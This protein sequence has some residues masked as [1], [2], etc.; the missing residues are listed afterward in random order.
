MPSER[1][2]AERRV[3]V[4]YLLL[5]VVLWGGNYTWVKIA[6]RDVGP[7]WFNAFRYGGAVLLFLAVMAARG[8]LRGL[9]PEP[10]E[11][12]AL[13][14]VGLLQAGLMTT[15]TA[16]ALRWTDASQVV[17]IAYTVPIWALLWGAAVLREAVTAGAALG[18]GLGLTGIAILTDPFGQTWQGGTMTG[19]AAALVGVNGWAL[20]AVLYR[21]RAWASSFWRQVWWQL[22]ATAL[23]MLVLAPLMEDWHEVRFSPS[24]LAVVAWNATGPTLLGFFFWAQAL[25]RV[26]AATAG[27]VMILAPVFGVLQSHLVLA[28]PLQ[29]GLILAALLVTAGA[30]LALR[31]A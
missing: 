27:Q 23:A 29:P 1:A 6:V 15:M 4:G 30:W 10:G 2:G 8:K 7:L 9:L 25:S 17:L 18:A 21:R 12:S 20:G 22:L 26:T 24:M 19:I 14:V 16:L 11:R 31:Q 13:A 5:L 28:E 3:A